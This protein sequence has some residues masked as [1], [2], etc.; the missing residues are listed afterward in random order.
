MAGSGE[1]QPK[2]DCVLGTAGTVGDIRNFISPPMEDEIGR[3][4]DFKLG[5]F[6]LGDFSLGSREPRAGLPNLVGETML[7][8][9]RSGL[10]CLRT[11]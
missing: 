3:L 9:T 7:S 11:E 4:G 10:P 8:L 5:D 6:I 2:L 1:A